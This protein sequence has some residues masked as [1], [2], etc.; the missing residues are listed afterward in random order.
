MTPTPFEV[1]KTYVALKMH[2]TSDYDYFKY[3]GKVK[4]EPTSFET[5]KDKYQFYKISKRKDWFNLILSN[6][7]AGEMWVGNMLTPEGEQKHVEWMKR[8]QSLGYQFARDIGQLR[9]DFNDNFVV[10]DNMHPF[11]LR[12]YLRKQISLETLI[13]LDSLAGIFKHWDKKLAND[14]MWKEVGTLAS[15]YKKFVSFDPTKMK[16]IVLTRFPA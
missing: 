15:K 9:D 12:M 5:R 10:E 7:V 1:Y 3:N 11:A 2:F 13:I 4:A 8:I 16:E 14:P 6:L